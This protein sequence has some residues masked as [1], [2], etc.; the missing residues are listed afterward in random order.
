MAGVCETRISSTDVLLGRADEGRGFQVVF[1]CTAN[2]ARSPFAAALMRRHLAFQPAGVQS[3]GTMEPGG[4]PALADAVRAANRFAID[5]SG[6]RAR[7]LPPLGL[8]AGAVV[9]GFEPFHVAAAVVVGGAERSR[10]F[11]LTELAGALE[12]SGISS[13][14]SHPSIDALIARVD[15][16]RRAREGFPRSIADPV[17]A[18]ERRFLEIFEEIDR[19][20][21]VVAESLVSA[22]IEPLD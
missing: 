1:V 10:S 17:G 3:F 13:N 19:L 2:R 21:A 8:D 12:A 18:S 14:A 20:V 5:L 16:H 9:I 7:P 6:H 22:G 4:A 15:G 11:L